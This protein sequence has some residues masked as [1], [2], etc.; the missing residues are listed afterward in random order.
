MNDQTKKTE[1]V[2][3]LS[4]DQAEA[5]HNLREAA[6]QYRRATIPFLKFT[7]GEF[8]LGKDKEPVPLGRK[9]VALPL[10]AR[11]GAECWKNRERVDQQIGKVASAF[12]VPD[13][14]TLNAD[15][16]KGAEKPWQHHVYLPLVSPDGEQIMMFTSSSGGGRYAF[17]HLIEEYVAKAGRHPGKAPVI[18]LGCSEY[19]SKKFGTI[20]EPTFTI[21]DWVDPPDFADLTV[22]K[23]A[24]K[25]DDEVAW[26]ETPTAK[27]PRGDMDD[28]IPF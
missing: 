20:Q 13:V 12:R 5:L 14:E 22:S 17:Y 27:K 6:K 26:E 21:T 11:H 10:E 15:T 2:V 24:E 19:E 9:S 3:A 28:E 1:N 25:T 18:S 4:V 7:K 16:P 23:D 8:Q